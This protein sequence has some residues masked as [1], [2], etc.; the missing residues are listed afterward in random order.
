V[1]HE[2]TPQGQ[3]GKQAMSEEGM[4]EDGLIKHLH[5]LKKS[6]CTLSMINSKAR[7]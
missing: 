7:E 1:G 2:K 4:I 3:N 6:D 5:V